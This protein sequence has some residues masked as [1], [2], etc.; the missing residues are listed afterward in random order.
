MT[1]TGIRSIM[2]HSRNEAS[3]WP[4]KAS[5]PAFTLIELLV[6]AAIILILI[7]ILIPAARHAQQRGFR[8]SCT[9]NLKQIGLAF[10]IWSVDNHDLLPAQALTNKAGVLIPEA[11]TNAYVHFLVMSNE[12]ATPTPLVCPADSKRAKAADFNKLRNLNTSYFVGL[13]AEDTT[14]D[15]FLSGDRN[16]TNGLAVTNRVLYLPTNRPAGWTHE[17]HSFN[18]NIGLADGSVQQ[19]N[20][21]RVMEGVTNARAANRL[22]MP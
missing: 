17:I 8:I 7:C 13:D 12:L 2:N 3:T 4:R 16:L 14:P 9:S 21:P 20:G 19:F 11:A 22:L 10:K 1:N 5:L 18:G 6:I 15:M